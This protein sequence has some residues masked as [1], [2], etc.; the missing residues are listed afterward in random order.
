ME[1][2]P[3]RTWRWAGVPFV[4]RSGKA[5]AW[6]RREIAVHFRPVPHLAFAAQDPPPNALRLQLDPDRVA[7]GVN[8]NGPGDP[9]ELEHVE[10]DAEFAPQDLPTYGRLLP[11]V[12]DGDCTLSIRADEAEESW[13][14]I[15][16]NLNAWSE[17]QV[18]LRASGRLAGTK[19]RRV[20]F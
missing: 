17:G 2:R 6:E 16:P 19:R 12:L 15:E 7:F 4:L 9:F 1:P 13:R 14:I 18:P 20:F 8:L 11:D 3:D 10:L 5:L